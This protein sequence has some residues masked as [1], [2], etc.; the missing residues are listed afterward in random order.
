LPSA[1]VAQ[2]CQRANFESLPTYESQMFGVCFRAD[3]TKS[4]ANNFQSSVSCHLP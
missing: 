2:H 1:H 4:E 3:F